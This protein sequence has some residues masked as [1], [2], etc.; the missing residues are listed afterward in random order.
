M[1]SETLIPPQSLGHTLILHPPLSPGKGST[2]G[3]IP[4]LPKGETEARE[5]G[6]GKGKA[7]VPDPSVTP[8]AA[9]GLSSLPPLTPALLQPWVQ[10]FPAS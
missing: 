2:H 4:R 10:T 7:E 1:D 3:I 5:V 9:R 6:W 8:D